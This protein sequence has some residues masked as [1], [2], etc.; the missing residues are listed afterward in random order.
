MP[1]DPLWSPGFEWYHSPPKDKADMRIPDEM[2]KCVCYVMVRLTG[3]EYKNTYK[4]L[5]TGFFVSILEDDFIFTY[6]VTAKH[7]LEEARDRALVDTIY[8]RVNKRGGGV[9]YIP[10]SLETGGWFLSANPADDIAISL[11]KNL[12]FLL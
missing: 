1:K 7:V 12:E 9:D 2:T 8:L 6:V 11:S 4:C 3:G 10:I 5:G